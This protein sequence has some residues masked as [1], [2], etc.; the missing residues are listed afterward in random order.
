M[1]KVRLMKILAIIAIFLFISQ[2]IY[3]NVYAGNSSVSNDHPTNP[4]EGRTVVLDPGH[5]GIDVGT[6]SIAGTY[7]KTLTLKTVKVVEQK[8]KNAGANV[9]LTRSDDAYVPLEQRANLSNENKADAF[10]SFH[11]NWLDDSSVNGVTDF[12]DQ[13]SRDRRLAENIL[14]EVVKTTG[15]KNAGTRFEDLNV[16][17]NNSQPSTLIE[18]GFLSNQQEDATVENPAYPDQV[19]Q[20]IYQG[21]LKYFSDKNK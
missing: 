20:G 11:Y 21:L 15:L 6:T 12:Y 17:R 7:E 10:I 14:T 19:A 9:I 1:K 5:G 2:K 16:L 13:K 18:L 4:L 3:E 8:L